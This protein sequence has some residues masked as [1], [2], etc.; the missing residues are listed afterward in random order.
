MAWIEVTA[1][2]DAT[3]DLAAA[4]EKAGGAR[5]SVANILRVHSVSPATMVAHLALYQ[6]LMFGR[7]ELTRVEREMIAVVVSVTNHCHY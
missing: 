3:S 4:Y 1:P 2:D 5:G 6:E 7:S